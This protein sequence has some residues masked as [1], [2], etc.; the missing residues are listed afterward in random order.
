MEMAPFKLLAIDDSSHT[1]LLVDGPTGEIVSEM[2][3]NIDYTPISL[4][5]TPDYSKAYMPAVSTLGKGALFAINLKSKSLYC[6]PIELPHPMQFTLAPDSHTAYFAAP[7]GFI[8]CL[9]T[10]TL[11]LSKVGQSV[12]ENFTCVG[13][14]ADNEKIYSAWESDIGGVVAVFDHSGRLLDEHLV[15]GI[16]TNIIADKRGLVS[17]PFTTAGAGSEGIVVFGGL[18]SG[19]PASLTIQCPACTKGHRAYPCYAAV[20]PD[21]RSVYI[22]N[23]DSGS[24]T[25]ADLLNA[26]AVDCFSIG[27]SISSLHILPDSRFAL[28]SSNMFGNLALIDLVN[29]RLLSF[30]ESQ[31]EILSCIAVLPELPTNS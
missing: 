6:L 1:L 7:N 9:D 28:A 10:T 11:T 21:Q 20:T 19:L 5:V 8:Y 4:V 13:L 22:V 17:V 16:P 2:A 15:N 23:E 26:T 14:V 30:T 25:V 31:R 12:S 29:G 18:R 3:Y 24:V 27:Q